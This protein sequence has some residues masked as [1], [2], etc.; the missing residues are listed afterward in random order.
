[1]CRIAP[2]DLIPMIPVN[3]P[4]YVVGV[5]GKVEDYNVGLTNVPAMWR[6]T[7]GSG[8]KVAILDTGM[9]QHKDITVVGANSFIRGYLADLNGHATACG[10][11]I[12]GTGN[13]GMGIVGIAPECDDYYGAVL[14]ESGAGSFKSIAEGIRWAVDV[15]KADV[16]NLSLGAPH[17]YGP[18][19]GVQKACEYAYES[20]VTVVAAAGNDGRDV[21]YPAALDTV[22]AVAAVDRK[23]RRASF[24]SYG[25]QVEF[26]AGGVDVLMAYKNGG[27]ASMSG[28]SFSAPVITGICAL[29]ISK[30]KAEG[31]K[32]TPDEVRAH[33]KSISYDLGPE[34][35]DDFTGWG[36]PVF[37]Q[38]TK[39]AL[40]RPGRPKIVGWLRRFFK[41]LFG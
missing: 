19:E 20:G 6:H 32:L 14:N 40:G 21:N 35:R 11:V 8:V 28:T 10:S 18:D 36:I 33:L 17:A 9:P 39:S 23:L 29:I 15:V 2:D 16:I 13:G 22:I 5:L 3:K 41:W 4:E 7:K 30:Y 24:S 12:A 26:A 1:M 27:Y 25:P 31:K 34:G 37:T 38:D